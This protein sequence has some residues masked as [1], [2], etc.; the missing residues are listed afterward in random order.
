M[1]KS[2]R[3]KSIKKLFRKNNKSRKCKKGGVGAILGQSST[4][5]KAPSD[6]REEEL[7]RKLDQA[8]ERWQD[9]IRPKNIGK[10][11]TGEETYRK[12]VDYIAQQLDKGNQKFLFSSGAHCLVLHVNSADQNNGIDCKIISY[13]LWDNTNPM[14]LNIN[15]LC[16]N[17]L[18]SS[19]CTEH[20]IVLTKIVENSDY[21]W[22]ALTTVES[23]ADWDEEHPC[24]R[25]HYLG[26]KSA[27]KDINDYIAE[28][29]VTSTKLKFI[30]PSI[31]EYFIGEYHVADNSSI[32][33]T[34]S[35]RIV[36][37]I[38]CYKG[39]VERSVLHVF[40]IDA[41]FK[42]CDRVSD[43]ARFYTCTI[44][45][46]NNIPRLEEDNYKEFWNDWLTEIRFPD[47]T[48]NL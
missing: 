41:I 48:G 32:I 1:K 25:R 14:V 26:F 5:G 24:S 4:P 36:I 7:R 21:F 22:R 33:S 6:Y 46:T 11:G 44:K 35:S 10:P 18:R 39:T 43:T 17:P 45:K 13:T 47:E 2:F 30:G 28:K 38:K 12:Y 31:D 34:V 3:K 15:P 27:E 19:E 23:I 9:K 16:T 40:D 42:F 20:R 37:R 8:D 29:R